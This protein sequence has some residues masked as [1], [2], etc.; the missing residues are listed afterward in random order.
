MEP[1]KDRYPAGSELARIELGEATISDIHR[2]WRTLSPAL[3]HARMGAI[4]KAWRHADADIHFSN[5]S[6]PKGH[7]DG[8]Q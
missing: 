8:T 2:A 5:V 4:L 3:A 7:G 1:R 6:P